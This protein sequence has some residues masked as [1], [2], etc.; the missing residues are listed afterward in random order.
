[1]LAPDEMDV[2]PVRLGCL[3]TVLVTAHF[4]VQM[5]CKHHIA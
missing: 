2:V 5:L 3:V 4:T 1:M